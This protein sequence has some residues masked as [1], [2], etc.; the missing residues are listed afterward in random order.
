MSE[1]LHA[2][3]GIPGAVTIAPGVHGLPQVVLTHPSGAGAAVYLH[4]AHVTSWTN[5]AGDE[6]LFV[7]RESYFAAGRPIRGGIP[8][9]FPQFG[10]GALPQHGLARTAAWRL[11][12]SGD[13]PAVTLG[14]T[15]SADTLAAW[16]H[17]FA[18][19][20]DVRLGA[21]TL[22]LTYTLRN[23]GAEPF[24]CHAVLHTYFGVGD[25]RRAALHGL[26]GTAYLDTL[27]DR[28]REVE[29]CPVLRFDQ[30]IDRIYLN[31]PDT[32]QLDDEARGLRLTIAKHNMP[33]VT[34]WNP[35][36][37]KAARTPDFGDDEY[38]RM[39]CVETGIMHPQHALAPG[40]AWTGETVLTCAAAGG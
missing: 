27:H 25:I 13:G 14:L 23:T 11:L 24:A 20:L 28:R 39:L 32:L 36:I 7:S 17:P 9:I 2:A 6:L 26:A 18:L 5:A 10:G 19:E 35:W 37:A 22:T 1:A 8:V 16:P 12:R 33:D 3:F 40:D 38:L 29:T 30:E 31:A 15:E 4:G 34:V 21:A